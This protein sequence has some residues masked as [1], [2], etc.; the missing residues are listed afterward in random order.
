M[1]YLH[2]QPANEAG[3]PFLSLQDANGVT[4]ANLARP[5]LEDTWKPTYAIPER[6]RC[7][8]DE[9]PIEYDWQYF[10][11]IEATDTGLRFVTGEAWP[12]KPNDDSLYQIASEPTALPGSDWVFQVTHRPHPRLFIGNEYWMTLTNPKGSRLTAWFAEDRWR[13]GAATLF[14]YP[15]GRSGG[16]YL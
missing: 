1:M 3:G 9:L 7:R 15:A 8:R 12:P 4:W 11:R 14:W 10:G 2:W 5:C 13:S 6:L 16:P